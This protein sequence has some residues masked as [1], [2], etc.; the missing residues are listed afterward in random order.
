MVVMC[1]V[2]EVS[3][4]GYHDW[5]RRKPS[6]RQQQDERYAVAIKA[7]HVKTRETYGARRLHKELQSEGFAMSGWKVRR[8][9]ETLGLRCKQARRFK[10]TTNSR[11]GLPV[12][13]NHVD[14]CFT[15]S[16]PNALWVTDIT[17]IP[18]D[19]GWLYLAGIKDVY[20]CEI[21]G[22]AM[23]SRMTQDLVQT[24]L[25][26]AIA[27][28]NPP[29]GLVHHSDRGSQYCAHDYQQQLTQAGMQVSMSRKGNCYDNAPM[30][31]FW[32]SLK[33]ELV[34]HRRYRTRQEAQQEITEYIELFYN[35][36]RRHSRLGDVAPATFYKQ[37]IQS[38]KNKSM[39]H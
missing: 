39:I 25:Q 34:H 28:K 26:R 29:S 9:R 36:Q 35:R 17:Y 16:Q 23:D 22:Y 38:M 15:P 12:A 7:A 37:F 20:T 18:S 33:N 13:A 2:L 4:S 5:I 10:A 27:A 19:E 32:G 24:A 14:Q 8:L 11:H 31:S 30:E 21:V 1:D 6:V 3:R